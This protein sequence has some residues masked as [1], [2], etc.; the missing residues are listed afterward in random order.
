MKLP[1]A[2][3][4]QSYHAFVSANHALWKRVWWVSYHLNPF[5]RL[6]DRL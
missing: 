2:V 5:L 1:L 6:R 3:L 4:N